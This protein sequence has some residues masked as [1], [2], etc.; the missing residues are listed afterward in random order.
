MEKPLKAQKIFHHVLHVAAVAITLQIRATRE[1]TEDHCAPSPHTLLPPDPAYPASLY[2]D[3]EMKRFDGEVTID[4]EDLD[5]TLLSLASHLPL[6]SSVASEDPH[7]V[8]TSAQ[9][10][11]RCPNGVLQGGDPIF[12]EWLL[13]V[14]TSKVNIIST[15]I[16]I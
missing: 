14:I 7:G 3:Y 12:F 4:K 9:V 5:L 16:P 6:D 10:K 15:W 1:A 11:I 13:L 8:P 2:S